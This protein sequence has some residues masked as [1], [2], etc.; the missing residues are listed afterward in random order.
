MEI[1]FEKFTIEINLMHQEE[2]HRLGTNYEIEHIARDVG[3][4]K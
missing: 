4:L 1:A 3:N 2:A